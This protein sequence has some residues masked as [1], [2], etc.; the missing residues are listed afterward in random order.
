MYQ[1]YK[2]NEHHLKNK[3]INHY[4]SLNIPQINI[5][6]I[7]NGLLTAN[8]HLFKGLQ[9]IPT[10]LITDFD[11]RKLNLKQ[12]TWQLI[13]N[14]TSS[15]K[16][17]YK[18]S[19][20]LA[21]DQWSNNYFHWFTET[22]PRLIHLKKKHPDSTI[23]LPIELQHISFISNCID[24]FDI[25]P[26]WIDPTKINIFQE[27]WYIHTIPPFRLIIPDLQIEL[28]ENILTR[29]PNK[30][31][32]P[33]RKL[34]ISRAKSK[35]RKI[36]NEMEL[37]AV[38]QKYGYEIV[39]AEELSLV[40]Q[41]ELFSQSAK[42]IA[43]HGAGLT[44]IMFMPANSKVLEIRN[45]EILTQPLCYFQLA[46]IFE[47]E[48]NYMTGQVVGNENNHNDIF[49]DINQFEKTLINFDGN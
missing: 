35:I 3:H 22:L 7:N 46:N 49:I 39:Y 8:N 17:Y 37:I 36:V 38:I 2:K 16:S 12:R 1:I 15:N 47:I 32:S 43:L 13:K 26:L 20:L 27:L 25:S 42:L 21:F 14:K 18:G 4:H 44:N 10:G 6:S 19:F 40:E 31:S 28:K 23:M 24:L 11:S 29:I 48:W 41:V 33:F 34:Y 9:F 30:E 5:C 45:P